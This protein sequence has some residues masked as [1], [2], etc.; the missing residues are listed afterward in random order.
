[1]ISVKN[2]TKCYRGDGAKTLALKD[3]TVKFADT[4]LY[5]LLGK[6][7]SG[8]S[9]L[10]NLL[11]GIIGE[12]SG[13]IIIDGCDV[14]NL[15]EREWDIFRNQNIGI[16]FQDYNLIEEYTVR[17]NVLLPLRI[18]ERGGRNVDEELTRVLNYVGL[19][20]CS[21]QKV[22]SLS[23]GQKQRVAIARALIKQPR[24]ILADEPT[25]NLDS[26]TAS[27]I[28]QLFKEISQTCLV[29]IV[30][31]D[32]EAAEV[33]ADKI[34]SI[35]DGEIIDV[36][37]SSTE[38][39]RLL[40]NNYI[41]SDKI[42]LECT[43]SSVETQLIKIIKNLIALSQKE[44]TAKMDINV[45]R[46]SKSANCYT[47]P[48]PI[49]AP[50]D[51]L[52]PTSITFLDALRF[53]LVGI[54]RR[55]LRATLSVMLIS[56]MMLFALTSVGFLTYDSS[57]VLSQYHKQY[58]HN[59]ITTKIDL[60]YRNKLLEWHGEEVR[61]GAF[62]HNQLSSVLSPVYPVWTDN[63]ITSPENPRLSFPSIKLVIVDDISH[64]ESLPITGDLPQ[65]QDEIVITDYL[66][67]RL[68]LSGKL[69]STVI[70]NGEKLVV[71]GILSTDFTQYDIINKISRGIMSQYTDYKIMNQYEIAIVNN[72]YANM[73]RNTCDVLVLPK[74]N[75]VYND[76][77]SRY[78]DSAAQYGSIDD[79]LKNSLI[80]GREV[81]KYDE[82]LISQDL[83]EIMELDFL[84]G[85][86]SN[87]KGHYIDIYN[88]EYNNAHSSALNLYN[89]FQEGYTIVGIFSGIEAD[90]QAQVLLYPPVFES[91]KNDY[92]NTYRQSEYFAPSA[93]VM[94]PSK[95][96]GL[97]ANGCRWAEPTAEFVYSF[98]SEL[99]KLDIYLAIIL[100]LC[101]IGII[102][103][104][105]SLISYSIKDQ[106]RLLGIL[107]S[108]GFTRRDTLK[109]YLWEAYLIGIISTFIS[110]FVLFLALSFVN[111]NF[112]SELLEYPY[113][114]ILFKDRY[115][116]AILIACPIIAI[117]ASL[118][119]IVNLSKKKPFDLLHP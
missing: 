16:V 92:F 29:C 108:L 61:S 45:E 70:L 75:L 41:D 84:E 74:S 68:N 71:T 87:V 113:R 18:L 30:S 25:G 26:V 54:K 110:A 17:E 60:I 35:A 102:L 99:H 83:A 104:C 2:V 46:L 33:Y 79:T 72:N 88:P 24:I 4:G 81:E 56:I 5:F 89:Y 42:I 38:G 107:R 8:K 78:L 28:F 22:S 40:I 11:S 69:G 119:P 49:C 103:L 9:T 39:Y 57:E 66:I 101:T 65:K 93:G 111:Q 12:Y 59:F 118:I 32:A 50:R 1:M 76:W 109:I 55:I 116:V 95:F 117:C 10:L 53:S 31:H 97:M 6:S 100:I 15:N 67:K 96:S 13:E 23:G 98:E 27:S 91:L 63:E 62:F 90:T 7:G 85:S 106:S 94:M 73:Q 86:F 34:I 82:I 20:R 115:L 48:T 3:C 77:E 51:A 58:R 64:I 19:L 114:L 14:S 37:T 80:A 36:D 52:M 105:I 112:M 47:E 43:E 21:E 44:G